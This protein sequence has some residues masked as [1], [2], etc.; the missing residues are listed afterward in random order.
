MSLFCVFDGHGVDGEHV[1]QFASQELPK[2]LERHAEL[3]TDPAKALS[4]AL[5]EVDHTLTK[6]DEIVSER[7]GCT[8]VVRALWDANS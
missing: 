4:E 2:V 1:S 7:C 3:A 5:I 8:A 6:R